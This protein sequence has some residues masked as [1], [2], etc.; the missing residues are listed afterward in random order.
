[1]SDAPQAIPASPPDPAA[2]APKESR[3]GRLLTLVRRLIDYGRDLAA[4]LQQQGAA[5]IPRQCHFG[6]TDL[7]LILARITQG[8]HRAQALEER[9][10]RNAARLDG[11][12]A[13]RLLVRCPQGTIPVAGVCIE[14]QA[15]PPAPYGSAVEECART[16]NQSAA[17]R[18][19]PTH[20]E[21]KA[22]LPYSQI[23]L[24]SSGELT[25]D[26][27]ASS[28]E[29]GR[30]TDLYV[31]DESGAVGLTPDTSAGAK[32]YRCVAPPLN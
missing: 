32:S 5:A 14:T 30:V 1:M 24:A 25:S 29:P 13:E 23:Q 27:S 9:I 3:V 19:L 21:L 10:T 28:S 8:L 16:D 12:S 17:G 6:T 20:D 22:A 26:V 18:R 2:G 15:R 31:T 11:V 4:S 7:A